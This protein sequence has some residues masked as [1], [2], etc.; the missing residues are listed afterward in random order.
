MIG[1]CFPEAPSLFAV[2]LGRHQPGHFGH[3]DVHEDQVGPRI[4]E[5]LEPLIAVI[6]DL[7][8]VRSLFKQARG[9]PLVDRV[10][11]GKEDGGYVGRVPL[12]LQGI[13]GD[14]SIT[15]RY[16]SFW[17]LPCQSDHR[18]FGPVIK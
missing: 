1:W 12:V 10:V 13:A 2:Q 14:E 15:Q 16:V 17:L 18:D 4:R 5:G 7:H 8:V 9:Q 3:L 6:D 11:L